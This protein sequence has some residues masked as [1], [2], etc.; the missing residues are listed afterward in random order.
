MKHEASF[1]SKD[2][3][4]KKNKVPSTAIYMGL[5]GLIIAL[6]T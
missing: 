5:Y 1:S 2:K 3:S 6:L 4:E